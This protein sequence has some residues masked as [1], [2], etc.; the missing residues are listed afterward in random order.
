[1][2][3]VNYYQKIDLACSYKSHKD[4]QSI[5]SDEN[6]LVYHF[7]SNIA[8][9]NQKDSV[10]SPTSDRGWLDNVFISEGNH[11]LTSQFCGVVLGPTTIFKMVS[12]PLQDLLGHLLSSFRYRAT[13]N[14]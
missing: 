4:F 11:R 14:L 1:M 8:N 2:I 5:Y 9:R 12:E 6:L 7:I 13:H 10:K 3:N